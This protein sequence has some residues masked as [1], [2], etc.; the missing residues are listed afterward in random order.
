MMKTGFTHLQT[1]GRS[2][3]LPIA[4]LPVAGLFL[5]L[6]QPDL[7]D[8]A[9]IAGSGAAIFGQLGLIFSI[10]VA[11]GFAREN[12]GAAALAAAVAFAVASGGAEAL[13]AV[14]PAVTADLPA[15]SRA[16]AAA[17]FK[18]AAANKFGVPLGILCGLAAGLLYNRFHAIKLPE[19][20]AFFGGRR[21]VPI[22]AG[23]AGVALAGLFGAGWPT[24]EQGM[25]GLSRAVVGAEGL[26][27]FLYGT[28]NRCLV[29][30]GLHHILNSIAW[31]LV[32]DFNGATGDLNRFFAGDP[33]AGAFMAGFFPVM[34]FG[35][36]GGCL[37]MYRA[38]RPERRKEVAGLLLSMALTSLLTGVTEPIEFTFM[39]VAPVLFAI[40]AVLTGLAHVVMDLLGVRLGFTFSAGMIDYVLNYNLGTRPWMLI[41]VGAVYFALYYGVFRFGISFFDLSTPGRRTSSP[42]PAPSGPSDSR[43]GDLIAAL[44]GAPNLIAVDAC[45]TRLRLEVADPDAVDTVALE[46]LG[47]RGVLRTGGSGLQ[48]VMGLDADRLAGQMRASLRDAGVSPRPAIEAALPASSDPVSAESDGDLAARLVSALG[49]PSNVRG[50]GTC[51]SRVRVDV[52]D[53]SC[54]NTHALDAL[55]FRGFAQPTGSALHLLFGPRAETVAQSLR[56]SLKAT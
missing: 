54:V 36:P 27:L 55:V 2:L 44:G 43:P 4:V 53:P 24:L 23:L 35:L 39:F 13:I 49:G 3:M 32:G 26:G 8:S 20:L 9:F 30:T 33:D 42:S 41:P 6:G 16:L 25:D 7:V 17:A 45:M 51:A 37:A 11:V 29:V 22:A 1:L 31:F 14:P 40:H 38:A 21:F 19:Y 34:I 15:S 50:I 48:V 18:E 52:V 46:A 56:L 28:L 12:H 47:A 5:R 10:G